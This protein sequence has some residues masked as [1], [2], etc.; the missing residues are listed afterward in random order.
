MTDE[1]RVIDFPRSEVSE[2]ERA[3]RVMVEVDRLA[4]LS[5]GE[6]KLWFKDSAQTFDIAPEMLRD[7]VETKLKDIKAAAHAAEI[8]KRRQEDRAERQRHSAEREETRKRERKSKEKSKA[9]A[10]IAK[11][12]SDR[13]EARL[14]ELAKLIE[15]DPAVVCEEFSAYAE[16]ADEITRPS[17]TWDVEPWPE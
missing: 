12:P 17:A 16:T 11:L 10:D 5:P 3:R 9:F 1:K 4:R 15:E 2:E 8:E 13:C 7:L 14:G 6:W